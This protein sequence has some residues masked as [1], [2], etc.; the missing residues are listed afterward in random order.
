MAQEQVLRTYEVEEYGATIPHAETLI[1][2][3]D[4]RAT[5]VE[6]TRELATRVESGELAGMRCEWFEGA[7]AMVYV[8]TFA[9]PVWDE[10]R[11]E[12]RRVARLVRC[13]LKPIERPALEVV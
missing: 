4:P 11:Q 7:A 9:K 5:F 8:E 12:M 2:T 13:E 1:H 3:D 6:K 10:K